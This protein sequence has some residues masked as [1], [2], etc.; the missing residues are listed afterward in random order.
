MLGA[1]R[2]GTRVTFEVNSHPHETSEGT[3]AQ[4][5]CS[6]SPNRRR[7]R[8][9]RRRI[10]GVGRDD[11]RRTVIGYATMIDVA[12]ADERLRPG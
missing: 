11:E 1:V 2:P 5:R 4:V 12:N 3:V 6:R 9:G 8:R 7:R 10:D